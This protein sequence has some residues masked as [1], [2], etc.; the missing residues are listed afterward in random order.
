VRVRLAHLRDQGI[1]FAVFAADAVSKTTWDRNAI[2]GRLTDK[3]RAGG[4]HITKAALQFEEYGQVRFYGPPDL[5][6]YLAVR[7]GVWTWTHTLHD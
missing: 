7:G 2:L 4:L 1:D 5:V 3:A 6:R